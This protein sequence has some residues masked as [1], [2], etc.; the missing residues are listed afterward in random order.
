MRTL[1]VGDENLSFSVCL[2][3]NPA[4]AADGL[5]V[6]CGVHE[7]QLKDEAKE[8]VEQLR[9]GGSRVHFGVNPA[10]L[11]NYFPPGTFD[12]VIL[13]LPGLAYHGCPS[14]VGFG[15]ELFVLRLHLFCFSVL[16]SSRPIVRANAEYQLLWP[17]RLPTLALLKKFPEDFHAGEDAPADPSQVAKAAPAGESDAEAAE[18]EKADKADEPSATADETHAHAEEAG[19]GDGEA[20][21]AADEASGAGNG[22]PDSPQEPEGDEKG[23]Q[24]SALDGFPMIDMDKLAKFCSIQRPL[25][26][27]YRLP[28]SSFG[29]WRPMVHRHESPENGVSG[30]LFEGVEEKTAPWL[31]RL[32]FYAFRHQED[33]KKEEGANPEDYNILRVPSSVMQ[34]SR[35]RL[36]HVNEL[37][38]FKLFGAR[39][40]S[41]LVSKL[42]LKYDPRI[43]GW[44][45]QGLG[46]AQRAPAGGAPI[47]GHSAP[48]AYWGPP[49]FAARASGRGPHAPGFCPH[50]GPGGPFYGAGSPRPHMGPGGLGPG[51]D[52]RAQGYPGGG[53]RGGPGPMCGPQSGALGGGPRPFAGGTGDNGY[54]ASGP[55][56][57]PGAGLGEHAGYVGS[58]GPAGRDAGATF[59]G[60]S[61]VA[62]YESFGHTGV[63][64]PQ[65]GTPT[66][67]SHGGMQDQPY[68]GYGQGAESSQPVSGYE[69]GPAPHAATGFPSAAAN[70]HGAAGGGSSGYYQTKSN[71]YS[72]GY[73]ANEAAPSGEDVS[74][75]SSHS[76]PSGPPPKRWRTGDPSVP[77]PSAPSPYGAYRQPCHSGAPTADAENPYPY[78]APYDQANGTMSSETSHGASQG[79][80]GPGAGSV[81]A[82]GAQ[83]VDSY[84]SGPNQPGGNAVGGGRVHDPSGYYTQGATPNSGATYVNGGGASVGPS[85]AAGSTAAQ[86]S[87]VSAGAGD[88]KAAAAGGAPGYDHLYQDPTHAFS[89]SPSAPGPYG[90]ARSAHAASATYYCAPPSASGDVAAGHASG[91]PGPSARPAGT[92]YGRPGPGGGQGS[93]AGYSGTY[94]GGSSAGGASASAPSNVNSQPG[95]GRGGTNGGYASYCSSAYGSAG[96]AAGPSSGAVKGRYAYGR[97]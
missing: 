67:Y 56:G 12:R 17:S 82:Y 49:H 76:F 70:S 73:G 18:E 14:L 38:L 8:F 66:G 36:P 63:G 71:A 40:V 41:L 21:G 92:G 28:L 55:A 4:F 23:M 46:A 93:T 75:Y 78:S 83:G 68:S 22:N 64:G 5:D 9:T 27:D 69:C 33:G 96:G 26:Q 74:S 87:S 95:T 42:S 84:Y 50:R 58:V 31:E 53:P 77:S 30:T 29:A 90:N 72:Y 7:E 54:G 24:P 88:A 39:S 89:R 45:G 94:G 65:G 3:G 25:N 16:K 91:A 86:W 32:V 51:V 60:S 52:V 80:W 1:V 97:F 48:G 59:A 2:A 47:G 6:A 61:A 19:S 34:Y 10:Q 57:S 15:S 44:R 62:R 81:S 13:V 85:A 11:R 35:E 37:F 20:P 43:A 79:G